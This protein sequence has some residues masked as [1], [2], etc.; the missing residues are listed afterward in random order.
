MSKKSPEGRKKTHKKM[1][2]QN[3]ICKLILDVSVLA[4]HHYSSS[5]KARRMKTYDVLDCN[6]FSIPSD[7]L[8]S[9]LTCNIHTAK[10]IPQ[11][12]HTRPKQQRNR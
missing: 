7:F 2:E 8:D 5:G 11:T 3:Q 1:Y 4:I 12:Y 9:Y 6:P 10:I